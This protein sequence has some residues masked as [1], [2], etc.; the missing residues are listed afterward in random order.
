MLCQADRQAG[1]PLRS[2]VEATD[3]D[4]AA[5]ARAD[6]EPVVTRNVAD[7]EFLGGDIETY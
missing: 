4:I 3:A 5:I 7:F 6:A 2:G 1:G